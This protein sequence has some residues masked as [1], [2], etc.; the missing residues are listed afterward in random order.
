MNIK[1]VAERINELAADYKMA[2]FQAIRKSLKELQRM[3]SR[4]IFTSQS[5]FVSYGYAFHWGGRKE[6]QYNIWE[7]REGFRYGLAF[8]LSTSQ[9]LPDISIFEPKI[10]RFNEFMGRH[11][12]RF[13][14]M[15]L[16]YY[17]P[18][19]DL[20]KRIEIIDPGLIQRDAFILFGKCL[21][22]S[23]DQLTAQDYTKILETFD[24]LLEVYRYVEGD[25]SVI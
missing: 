10:K 15:E 20:G 12:H 14:D 23:L 11:S 2:E 19:Q 22:K 18:G 16:L 6:I 13:S 24:K 5:I 9:T 8:S 7:V 21:P 4:K 1:D 25:S 17:P 3:A